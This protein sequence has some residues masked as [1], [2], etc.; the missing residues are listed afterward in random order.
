MIAL[1]DACIKWF[2]LLVAA[3][4]FLTLP[5]LAIPESLV[6]G[7]VFTVSESCASLLPRATRKL[8]VSQAFSVIALPWVLSSAVLWRFGYRF[9]N[10]R[11]STAPP[12]ASCLP[13]APS[14]AEG[15]KPG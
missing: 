14:A 15:R 2:S 6:T 9:K 12:A 11:I 13:P 4:W 3:L 7:K 10:R 1:Y 8:T 5:G